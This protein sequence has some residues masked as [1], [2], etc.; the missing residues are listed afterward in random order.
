MS[1]CRRW[2]DKTGRTEGV[3]KGV[4]KAVLAP[5]C[6]LSEHASWVSRQASWV[7]MHAPCV[8]MC[9]LCEGGCACPPQT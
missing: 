5:T 6:S 9:P 8:R 2:T 4:G 3:G 1:C 7:S